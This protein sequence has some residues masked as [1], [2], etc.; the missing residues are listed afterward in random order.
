MSTNW[1]RPW[2]AVWENPDAVADYESGEAGAFDFLV[3]QVMQQPGGSLTRV[4]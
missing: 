2:G 4:E 3:D 1:R